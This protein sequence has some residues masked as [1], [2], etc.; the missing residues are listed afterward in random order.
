MAPE[1]LL[2]QLNLWMENLCPNSYPFSLYFILYLYASIWI[3]IRISNTDPDPQHW[4]KIKMFINLIF[5]W[6]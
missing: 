1:E 2:C 4:K 3:R 5:C 6:S